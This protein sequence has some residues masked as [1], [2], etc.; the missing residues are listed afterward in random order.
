MKGNS[1]MKK[2]LLIIGVISLALST[3]VFA[4]ENTA[5]T[6]TTPVKAKSECT[7]PCDK[8]HKPPMAPDKSAFEKRLKL[9]D[10]QKAQAK[11]IHQKG[12]EEIKPIMDKIGLKREEIGAVKRSKLSPEAQAEK[13]VQIRKEIK[14]LKHQARNI[15][16][17]NMKEFEAILTDK[18]KKELNKIKEEGRKKFEA[19]HKKN[20]FPMPP[21]EPRPEF[22]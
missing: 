15:Q 19:E 17:K 11:E 14:E 12:F 8:M 5:T 20:G 13:I 7:K 10:A 21:K 9:T 1:I 6:S 3:Q 16:M 22:E 4:A 2:V 18:Q